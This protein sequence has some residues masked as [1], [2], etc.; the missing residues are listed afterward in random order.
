MAILREYNDY[1]IITCIE[2]VVELFIKSFDGGQIGER[3][4]AEP[5]MRLGENRSILLK[6]SAHLK[7]LSSM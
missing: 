1:G 6:Y 3:I 5:F 2:A 7:E 4:L